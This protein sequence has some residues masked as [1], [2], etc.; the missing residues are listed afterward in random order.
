MTQSKITDFSLTEARTKLAAFKCDKVVQQS[1]DS[2]LSSAPSFQS[3]ILQDRSG[4]IVGNAIATQRKAKRKA[5]TSSWSDA[6]PQSKLVIIEDSSSEVSA[7]PSSEVKNPYVQVQRLTPPTRITN[8]S[9]LHPT[10]YRVG[11]LLALIHRPYT[12]PE[13]FVFWASVVDASETTI[14]FADIYTPHRAPFLTAEWVRSRDF[15]GLVKVI[16]V[17]RAKSK[18]KVV[19]IDEQEW[20]EVH[21]LEGLLQ[22]AVDERASLVESEIQRLFEDFSD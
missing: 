17:R 13:I 11:E 7:P 12:S 3:R 4:N 20:D 16:S 14:R 9:A 1:D 10:Q 8:A 19:W 22:Q 21:V 5:R 15:V 6:I 18:L 2:K